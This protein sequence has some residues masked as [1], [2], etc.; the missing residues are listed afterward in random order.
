MNHKRW[1]RGVYYRLPYFRK[2]GSKALNQTDCV[3]ECRLQACSSG[4]HRDVILALVPPLEVAEQMSRL[5]THINAERRACTNR[6]RTREE[7]SPSYATPASSGPELCFRW[8]RQ[9][10]AS[11]PEV[12]GQLGPLVPCERRG[13]RRP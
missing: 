12:Q 5:S 7:S 10:Q 3:H 1:C 9:V 11:L 4:G 13:R 6:L 8:R 2:Y